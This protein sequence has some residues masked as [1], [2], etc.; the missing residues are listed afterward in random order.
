MNKPRY[1]E[2]LFKIIFLVLG[3]TFVF[4]G[5]LSYIGILKPNANSMV[6]ESTVLGAVFGSLGLAFFIV[7][8]V[9]QIIVANKNKFH[10][11]LISSGNTVKGVVEK[12]CLKKYT[13]YGKKHPYRILYTYSYHG[14]MYRNK[15][16]LLWE[17]PNVREGDSLVVYVN[18]FGKSTVIL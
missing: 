6:Q 7:Q 5:C 12:V 14:K 17:I 11:K 10:S 9:L 4:M 18:D 13:Q 3:I 1:M 15:S 16:C 8:T 2:E